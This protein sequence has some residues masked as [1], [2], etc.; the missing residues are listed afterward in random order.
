MGRNGRILLGCGFLGLGAWSVVPGMIHPISTDAVV[1]AEVVTVRAPVDGRL[2]VGQRLVVGDRVEL[3]DELGRVRADRPDTGR[4]DALSLDLAAQRQL[5]AA[6]A[7][8]ERELAALEGELAR[9]GLSYR[10]AQRR[11]LDLSRS[12]L[13]ARI[14]AAL[15]DLGRAEAELE[16]KRILVAKGHLAPVTEKTAQAAVASARAEVA[17]GRAEL[18][19][20]EAELAAL[21][22]G[23]VASDDATYSGQRRD[24]IRIT[25]AARRVEAAQAQVRVAE[26]ARQLAAENGRAASEVVMAAPIKGVV[27]QRFAAEGDAVRRGDPVA[28]V[29]DCDRLFLTAVLPK[30]YFPEL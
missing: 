28:G 5:A 17:A 3:G 11:R 25:R 1:N 22:R 10:Q 14:A 8:E 18:G 12:E 19:R 2:T 7:D 6:L 13:R 20:V 23:I 26:L 27:W 21:G 9:R 24:E 30:R 29:V 15:A 4:R 16:R